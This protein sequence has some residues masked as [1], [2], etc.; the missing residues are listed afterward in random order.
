MERRGF[1]KMAAVAGLAGAAQAQGAAQNST[2]T[3][4]SPKPEIE[5]AATG[6][7]SKG[8]VFA[9]ISPHLDDGPI[10]ARRDGGEAGQRGVHGLLYPPQQR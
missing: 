3:G 5:R 8:K 4:A 10:F 1:F 2:E 9:L 7:P 6:Q